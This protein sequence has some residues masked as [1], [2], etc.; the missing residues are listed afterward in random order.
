MEPRPYRARL[1]QPR[2]VIQKIVGFRLELFPAHRGETAKTQNSF[3]K[4]QIP[5]EQPPELFDILQKTPEMASLF[6][7]SCSR[8]GRK[9]PVKED[10]IPRKRERSI[11]DGKEATVQFGFWFADEVLFAANR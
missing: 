1:C 5:K 6:S 8:C 7:G 10:R 9:G 2:S 11:L 4:D 3:L